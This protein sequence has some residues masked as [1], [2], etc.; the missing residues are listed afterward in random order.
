MGKQYPLFSTGQTGKSVQVSAQRR[1]NMYAEPINAEDRAPLAFF[2]RPGL[3]LFC[4]LGDTPIRGMTTFGD[5]IYAV[6]R[7]SMYRIST[8]G[9]AT[10]IGTLDTSGGK[11]GRVDMA[12]NGLEVLVVDG[13]E[14]YIYNIAAAT[15]TKIADTDF[16][17]ANTCAYQGGRFIVSGSDANNPGRFWLSGSYDGTSW[18]GTDFATAEGFTDDLVR[19]YVDNN[20][21]FL[22][23][24]DSVE[25]WSNVGALDFPYKRIDGATAEWGLRARWSIATLGNTIAWLAQNRMGEIQAMQM[26]GYAPRRISTPE[27]EAIWNEYRGTSNASALSYMSAGHSFY[28]LNFQTAGVSWV[29]DSSTGLWSEWQYGTA[30]ERHRAEFGV[31]LDAKSMVA[32]YENGNIYQIDA[33]RLDDNGQVFAKELTS[34]HVFDGRYVSIPELWVDIDTGLAT[35]TGSGSDPQAMLAISKDGGHVYGPERWV[36]IGKQGRYKTRAIWRRLGNAYEWTFKLRVS[37]PIQVPITS[38]WVM[39]E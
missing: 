25:V 16:P 22:F 19:V 14:G 4:Q 36:G 10:V 15:F 39:A 21:L 32:D 35:A 28:Q 11:N 12:V 7:G 8:L 18:D 24:D 3:K 17:V 37:D 29:Y 2:Q 23:G 13:S 9:T 38:A 6:H 5:Y 31:Q 26:A 30:G 34:R 27:V 1:V 33:S 20:E